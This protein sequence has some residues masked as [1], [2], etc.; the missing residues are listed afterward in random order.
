MEF[1]TVGQKPNFSGPFFRWYV[2]IN[3]TRDGY[4]NRF[5]V[6]SSGKRQAVKEYLWLKMVW[7][8]L[9]KSEFELFLTMKETLEDE[10]IVGF[11]RSKLILPLGVLRSRLLGF[12]RIMGIGISSRERYIGFKRL[13]VEIRKDQIRLKKVPKFSGYVRNIASI[14]K[15]SRGS[16][17]KPEPIETFLYTVESQIDW[18]EI[19]SVGDLTLLGKSIRLPDENQKV[20]NGN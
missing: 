12:E 9:S 13:R 17:N 19:L 15:G 2:T 16:G 7:D 1:P 18:Y 6:F 8:Q 4:L 20:R 10:K 14:G 3:T 11:L 5:T